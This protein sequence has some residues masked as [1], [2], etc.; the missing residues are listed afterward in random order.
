MNLVL[1]RE[2]KRL[3]STV[4]SEAENKRPSF[5]DDAYAKAMESLIKTVTDEVEFAAWFLHVGRDIQHG[6]GEEANTNDPPPQCSDKQKSLVSHLLDGIGAEVLALSEWLGR[7]GVGAPLQMLGILDRVKVA[8]RIL[9]SKFMSVGS[10]PIEEV[11]YS[12][13]FVWLPRTAPLLV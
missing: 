4:R 8:C 7:S 3:T 6:E 10:L 1:R 2:S 12:L 13:L 9:R 11:G 5:P